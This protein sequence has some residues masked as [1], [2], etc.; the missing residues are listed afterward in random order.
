MAMRR[1]SNTAL[2]PTTQ[3]RRPRPDIYLCISTS[4]DTCVILFLHRRNVLPA[5][6]STSAR[7]LVQQ[8]C[9]KPTTRQH[10]DRFRLCSL[11]TI[12]SPAAGQMYAP[13]SCTFELVP[14]GVTPEVC[15]AVARSFEHGVPDT[16]GI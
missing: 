6:P 10:K 3:R 15:R 14:Q 8:R 4:T 2:V 16:T 11:Y 5:T 9:L 1:L 12:P 7:R 13:I